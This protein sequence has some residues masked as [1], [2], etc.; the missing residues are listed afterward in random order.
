MSV[1]SY[2][3]E[4]S[5]FVSPKYRT[6]RFSWTGVYHCIFKRKIII[7]YKPAFVK[8]H[9]HFRYIWKGVL[10][11]TVIGKPNEIDFGLGFSIL[12][13][14]NLEYL[15]KLKWFLKINDCKLFLQG[16]LIHRLTWLLMRIEMI[17]QGRIP[18][19]IYIKIEVLAIF[20]FNLTLVLP[21]YIMSCSNDSCITNY[22]TSSILSDHLPFLVSTVGLYNPYSNNKLF[23][24]GIATYLFLDRTFNNILYIRNFF[25]RFYRVFCKKNLH[26]NMILFC[27]VYHIPESR[28]RFINN[29]RILR[30]IRKISGWLIIKRGTSPEII[31][32][33]GDAIRRWGNENA[34]IILICVVNR[35]LIEI[36]VV[37]CIIS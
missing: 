33:K 32:F 16:K 9:R 6:T 31:D 26:L 35:F 17:R 24:I 23:Q 28:S 21:K 37:S 12:N 10:F 18:F 19:I 2:H 25:A 13:C 1:K 15:I 4:P 34:F 5:I 30:M 36:C 27:R 29:R 3:D 22:N 14:S 11:I 8:W 20:P 7:F